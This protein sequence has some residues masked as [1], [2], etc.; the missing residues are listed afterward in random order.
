M[1]NP[2]HKKWQSDRLIFLGILL[3]LFGL[4]IG[5]FVP[6]MTNQRMGLSAH[7]EGIMN[8]M[9]LVILGLIWNKLVLNDKWLTSAFW[10]ILYGSF[11][12]FVAVSVAAFTGAGK[13][14]PLAGGKEGTSVVEGLISFLLISLGLAMIF[15]CLILLAGFLR[16]IK[17]SSEIT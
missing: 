2:G 11:A 3:F 10:L 4:L 5:L 14:M 16:Y 15:V 1:E 17:Q 12:N 7:L 9:F 6:M 13:M 8:G